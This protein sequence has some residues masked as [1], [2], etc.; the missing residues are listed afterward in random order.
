MDEHIMYQIIYQWEKI[1]CQNHYIL[2][3][4]LCIM[5]FFHTSLSLAKISRSSEVRLDLKRRTTKSEKCIDMAPSTFVC[6]RIF[7]RISMV[8]VVRGW[9]K[10]ENINMNPLYL[11]LFS[12]YA[13]RNRYP[14]YD[15]NLNSQ[16]ILYVLLWYT[17]LIKD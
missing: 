11:H 3:C 14:E 2:L 10:E 4:V 17:C 5:F 8:L 1:L 12:I 6:S 9:D 16:R 15:F 7:S 13:L